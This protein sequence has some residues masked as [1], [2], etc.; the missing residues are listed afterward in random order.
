M[1]VNLIYTTIHQHATSSLNIGEKFIRDRL[2]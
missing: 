2:L 1:N